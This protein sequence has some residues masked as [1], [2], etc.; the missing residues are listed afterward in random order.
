MRTIIAGTALVLLAYLAQTAVVLW[1]FGWLPAAVY[2]ISLPIAADVNFSLTDR[3]RRAIRRAR[4]YL[5]LR[6]DP[7]FRQRL[8]AELASLRADVMTFDCAINARDAP[9]SSVDQ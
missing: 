7:E 8:A 1:F 4:A 2:F 6:R 3:L 9:T 5:L